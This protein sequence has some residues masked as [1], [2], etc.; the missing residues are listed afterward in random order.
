MFVDEWGK[1]QELF[2]F[3][4]L[5]GTLSHAPLFVLL[6][7]QLSPR[8]ATR[9]LRLEIQAMPSGVAF[10]EDLRGVL[11]FMHADRFLDAKTITELT[12]IPIRTIYRVLQTW[13]QTGEVKPASEGKQGRPRA[14]DFGDTQV[15]SLR[16]LNDAFTYPL[17]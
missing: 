3:R 8:L 2:V 11:I 5:G 17:P 13:R 7:H 1:L 6:H 10:S 15:S 4:G 9:R 12:G 16:G 14:L